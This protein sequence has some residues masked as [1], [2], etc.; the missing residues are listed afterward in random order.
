MGPSDLL[1]RVVEVLEALGVPY[2]VTGSTATIFYGEPRFTVDV[3]V[4]VD[5]PP[6]GVSDLIAA[7]QSDEYYV[8][9]DSARRAV[10]HR[11]QFNIIHPSSG[12]KID[13]IIPEGGPFDRS[14]F[15]RARRIRPDP[16]FE[17]TFASP[18]DVILKK[19]LYYREGGSEKHLR[20]ITGILAVSSQGLDRRYILHWARKLDVEDLWRTVVERAA[21]SS[22]SEH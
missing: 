19:L 20:D 8:D 12:L 17:A 16:T 14:R 5:L 22:S 2:L 15:R 4:V 6:D 11:S 18:E 3:D 21:R 1:R 10:A 7:F 13:V 9:E